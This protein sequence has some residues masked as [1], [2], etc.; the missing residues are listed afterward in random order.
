MQFYKYFTEEEAYDLDPDLM[1]MLD[2]AR[3]LAGVPFK[4]TSG[5]RTPEY[6]V[7]HGRPADGPHTH[8]YAVDLR[9]RNSTERF[10]ILKG[11]FGVGFVRIGVEA[12]HIHADIDVSHDLNVCWRV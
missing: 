9:C 5:Y 10:Y 8:R 4:I 12:D 11:L 7:A 3:E 1:K 6:E 2:K